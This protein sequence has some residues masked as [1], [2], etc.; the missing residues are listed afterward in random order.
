MLSPT[1]DTA[2]GAGHATPSTPICPSH[3]SLRYI[4]ACGGQPAWCGA[5]VTAVL[6]AHLVWEPICQGTGHSTDL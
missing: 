3:C 1:P 2:V 4:G 5:M 6:P